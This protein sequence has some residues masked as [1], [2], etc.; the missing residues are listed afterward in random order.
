M[1]TKMEKALGK[2]VIILISFILLALLTRSFPGRWSGNKYQ[3]ETGS[4][5][6]KID[7]IIQGMN[8]AEID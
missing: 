6:R 3:K 7:E 5:N 4:E 8:N 1:D 2:L